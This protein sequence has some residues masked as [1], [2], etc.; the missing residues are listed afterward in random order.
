M[1]ITSDNWKDAERAIRE[2]GVQDTIYD[3]EGVIQTIILKTGKR[4]ELTM[5]VIQQLMKSGLID[6]KVGR[7]VDLNVR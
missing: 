6:F 1:K 4:Y 2:I 7:R 5:D 3:P